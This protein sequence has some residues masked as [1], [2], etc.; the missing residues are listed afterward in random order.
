[1]IICIWN[2]IYV[3]ELPLN[4][5]QIILTYLHVAYFIY[6]LRWIYFHGSQVSHPNNSLFMF[7]LTHISNPVEA[8]ICSFSIKHVL[9]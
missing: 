7:K 2:V 6:D 4:H 1:M 8:G 3:L 5:K 9:I